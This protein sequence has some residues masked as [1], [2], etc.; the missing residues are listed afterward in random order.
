MSDYELTKIKDS[1]ENESKF[2]QDIQ[3]SMRKVIIGQDDLIEKLLLA[4][5]SDGHVFL[6]GVPGLA[7]TLTIKSLAQIIDTKFQRL[8]FTPD[9][10]PADILGTLIYNQKESTFEIKKGP[11]TETVNIQL[12]LMWQYKIRETQPLKVLTG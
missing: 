11:M 8:Q 4:I 9:L 1:I 3:D 5:L 6:E 7:K 2:I 10:L 12:L